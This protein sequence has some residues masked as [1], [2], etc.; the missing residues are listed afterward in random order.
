MSPSAD[1][2]VSARPAPAQV[3][4]VVHRTWGFSQLRPLQAEAIALAAAGRDALV[5]LPTGGGKSLCYQVP[6]LLDGATDIVISPL[7]SLMNDQVAGLK[8]YGYPAAAL[9]SGLSAD[10]AREAVRALVAGEL[11]LLYVSPEKLLTPWMLATCERIGVKRFVVDEAHCISQWGHDFRPEYRRLAEVRERFPE[12]SFHA[13]T[14]TATPRVREDIV[15]QLHLHQAKTL[16]GSFDRPNLTFRVVPMIDRAKQVI[17]AVERHVAEGGVIVY[18][19]SRKDTEA[20]AEHLKGR[21]IQTACYHAGLSPEERLRVQEAFKREDLP[22][23]VATVAFGMGIDRSNVRCVVHAAMPKSVEAYTQE[24]GRAGRDG[25]PAECVLLY[26]A[27]DAFRWESLFDRSA[28]EAAAR[29]EVADAHQHAEAQKAMLRTVQRFAAS[30]VC[31]HRALCEYFGQEYAANANKVDMAVSGCGACDHCLG[32]VAELPDA[33]VVAQKIL[34]GVARTGNR[35]GIGQVVDVLLGADTENVKRFNHHEL[36]VFGLLKDFNK[37]QLT[38]LVYQLL[39]LGVLARSE[40]EYPTLRLNEASWEVMRG[41]KPVRLVAPPAAKTKEERS[42]RKRASSTLGAP[43]PSVA[44]LTPEQD[45]AFNRLR[46]WRKD[47]A[48]ARGVPPYVLLHDATLVELCLVRPTNMAELLEVRGMG[49]KK[50]SDFGQAL[51]G[52]I[53]AV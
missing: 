24:A 45:A 28:Q 26:T 48:D 36:T 23:V 12:A 40:G 39:D 2:T 44:Q 11:R 31:R 10:E 49:E 18:C 43:K 51:I 15:A 33:T 6:P 41:Q 30:P 9:H 1:A 52:V 34:S 35:F 42:G 5:V 27:A 29:G 7:I 14:A 53:G 16:V 32:E 4:A 21:G 17:Q 8:A 46:R 50:A 20:M 22:V 47:E 19:I 3:A 38:A 13:F 37:K 25:L